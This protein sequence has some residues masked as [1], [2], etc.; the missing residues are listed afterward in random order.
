M[1]FQISDFVIENVPAEI[2]A[3]PQ[4]VPWREEPDPDHKDKLT[5]MPY[6][7]KRPDKRAA[8]TRQKE[9]ATFEETL[10]AAAHQANNFDGV[11]FV[12]TPPYI[13]LDID[14]C[15]D[16]ETGVPSNLAMEYISAVDSYTEFSTHHG[17][18]IL[19]RGNVPPKQIV[20]QKSHAEEHVELYTHNRYMV[21]TSRAF[22]AQRP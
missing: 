16:K 1:S 20:P 11:G 12:V 17:I 15:C 22:F 10:A 9:W 4:W 3:L 2:R 14:A 5:K 19:C 6:Q 13:F 21:V 8:T 7:A 18:H